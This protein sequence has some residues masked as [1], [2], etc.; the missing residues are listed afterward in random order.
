MDVL[1][2]FKMD[3]LCSFKM[4]VLCFFKMDVLANDYRQPAT[5]YLEDETHGGEDVAVYAR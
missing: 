3:V 5:F 4:D 2:S 1:C